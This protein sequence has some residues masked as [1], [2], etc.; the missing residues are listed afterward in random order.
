MVGHGLLQCLWIC[1]R[2]TRDSAESWRGIVII[3]TRNRAIFSRSSCVSQLLKQLIK[4]SALEARSAARRRCHRGAGANRCAKSVKYSC[5]NKT[6]F[7]RDREEGGVIA[8]QV[9][10]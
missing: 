3:S 4:L 6:E 5:G 9:S 7:R 10:Q 1:D 8:V 2:G